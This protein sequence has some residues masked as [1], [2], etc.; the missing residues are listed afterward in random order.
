MDE[1]GQKRLA[2]TD[3][4]RLTHRGYQHVRRP[5]VNVVERERRIYI[6][7][8][9]CSIALARG[10]KIFDIF[11][12]RLKPR[13]TGSNVFACILLPSLSLSFCDM[14]RPVRCA[15]NDISSDADNRF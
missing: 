2:W 15:K 4:K 11:W 1:V 10:Q 13:V 3:L 7:I 14:Q 6:Y 12:Q 5:S 9:I 8:Y